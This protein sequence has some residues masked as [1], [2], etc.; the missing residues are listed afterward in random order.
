M[1]E[2]VHVQLKARFSPP[3]L[4]SHSTGHK[5]PAGFQGGRGRHR[6]LQENKSIHNRNTETDTDADITFTHTH[7]HTHKDRQDKNRHPYRQTDRCK[8]NRYKQIDTI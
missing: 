7:R 6:I 1:I 4:L 3:P 8:N 2:Y 5:I